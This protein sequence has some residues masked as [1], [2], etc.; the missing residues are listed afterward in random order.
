MADLPVAEIL[1]LADEPT[2]QRWAGMLQDW[3]G[4]VWLAAEDVPDPSRLDL[5]LTD[6]PPPSPGRTKDPVRRALTGRPRRAAG[7][8]VIRIGVEGP[9]DVLL[10]AEVT[11]R[12]LRTACRLLTEVV[13]LR[14]KNDAQIRLRK[15][16]A[17]RALTDPLSGLPNRRAW[18]QEL[19]LRLTE[20]ATGDERLCLAI[21]DLDHF[22]RINDTHGHATGDEVL[23]AAGSVISGGLREDDFVARLGGDEFALLL[24]VPNEHSAQAVVDRVRRSL[25]SGLDQSGVCP[26]AASAGFAVAPG[27][28]PPTPLPSPEALFTAA[29]SALREAKRQ[30]RDRTIG[31]VGD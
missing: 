5:I 2:G 19:R 16:L 26:A 25:P 8:G 1:I 24:F 17:R 11:E 20:A 28:D 13:R 21:L 22:K 6:H 31:K 12:E 27:G 30:G 9:A 18:E 14:R 7:P 4:R 15:K 10:P 29:D 3:P 23:R